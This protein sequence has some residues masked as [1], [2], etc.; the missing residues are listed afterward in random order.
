MRKKSTA[1]AISLLLL[2]VLMTA[3][4]AA[5]MAAGAKQTAI[6]GT[7]TRFFGAPERAWN[8]N[9]LTQVRGLALTGTFVFSGE[10]I[11]LAGSENAVVNATLFV[12]GGGIT[13]G[14]VT[15]TDAA[16]GVTC[17]GTVIGKI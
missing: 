16:T 1:I 9:G 2:S 17:T 10:G 7:E 8:I 5:P 11:T 15:Y 14:K 12:D 4:F 3:A 13:W 6:T